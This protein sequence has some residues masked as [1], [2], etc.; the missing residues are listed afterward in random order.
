MDNIDW[1]RVLNSGIVGG[2]IGLVIAVIYSALRALFRR[3]K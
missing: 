1:G 3:K 2:L